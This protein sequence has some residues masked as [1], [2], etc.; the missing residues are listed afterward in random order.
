[1]Q[2]RPPAI[3]VA[4]QLGQALAQTVG[5]NAQAVVDKVIAVMRAQVQRKVNPAGS[6]GIVYTM[7]K[8][9]CAV[10]PRELPVEHSA[11]RRELLSVCARSDR[12]R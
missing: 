7:T 4:P 12:L 9:V 5:F 8:K 3:R 1:M 10:C 6:Y 2:V 11:R